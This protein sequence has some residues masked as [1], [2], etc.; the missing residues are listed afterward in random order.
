MEENCKRL[1]SY[2]QKGNSNLALRSETETAA[3][4]LPKIEGP[5]IYI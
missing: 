2:P 3:L 1:L 4:L 5:H